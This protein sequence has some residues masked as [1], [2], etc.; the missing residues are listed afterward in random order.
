M[1]TDKLNTFSNG[2]AVT[3]TAASTDVIDLG[4]L[5]HGNTRRDIGAG[6]PIYLVVAALT[7]ATAAGAA[8]TNI[9]LQTSD[10]NSTWVTLFD[11]GSLAL[12]ALTA[13]ARPVQVAVPRGVRRYLRVNY[14][15]G[16]GPLTAGSFFA[17]LVKDVQDNT[18]YASG[19]SIL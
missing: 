16:T 13:G 9:Q 7:A 3:A 19:F 6:E 14:V 10:D 11:S 8:T 15:I 17:G 12:A 4:P 2:Q 18:K 5:T 1:I